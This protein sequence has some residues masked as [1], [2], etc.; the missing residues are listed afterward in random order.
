[1]TTNRRTF[2]I[3][4]LAT[5][6]TSGRVAR[7]IET[8]ASAGPSAGLR[9]DE[10]VA[11]LLDSDR[12][13]LPE[14]LVKH[15]HAGL[16]DQ[17]LLGA[18]AEAA[19]RAVS[20]Y[21][22][23]GFKYHAFMML[24]AVQRTVTQGRDED[25]WPSLLWAADVLKASQ[26]T[27]V[28]QNGWRMEMVDMD[29]VPAPGQAEDAF[30]A[31]ME[32][33]D[34]EA[35]DRAVIG[36]YRA[37]P[38]ERLFDLLFRY[39]ARDFR[40][41]G[42]K[43]ITATNCHRLLQTPGWSGA[44]PL[45]RSLTY[46]LQNHADEPNPAQNDLAADRPWR[47]NL[48]LAED[49]PS[50][51]QTGTPTPAAI[52]DLLAIFREGSATDTSRAT[53]A[54]FRQGVDPQTLW[55]V[56]ILAAGELLLRRPG[57][58]AIHANTTA[59][60]LHQGYRRSGDDHTRRMLMLQ[61]A[62]FMPLFRDQLGRG[63]RALTIDGLEPADSAAEPDQQLGEIFAAIGVDR[64]VAA[65]EALAY[66]QG[67]GEQAAFRDLARHYTVDRNLGYHDYKLIEAMLENARHLE[68]PWQ[69]RYLAVSVYDLNGPGTPYNAAVV[70]ARELLRS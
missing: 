14:H 27:E 64:D 22:V 16:E 50:D 37:V 46:A 61:A 55:T 51:W 48:A 31:A 18:I 20:P 68:A 63:M 7:A 43:A 42:H 6:L 44:E 10:L 59:E 38:K 25:R 2:L 53:A 49:L 41:I 56:I 60:A 1:M 23:V 12:E 39:S 32:R 40:S 4:T 34:P 29:R 36:L 52:P 57:I 24:H 62:A 35:A 33:W 28:R 21:P 8:T 11:L 13:R 5:T 58:V 54:A 19:A 3:G 65:R 45:L 30:V 66:F 69:A 17:A 47:E 15:I 26:A 9:H 67:T 70:R